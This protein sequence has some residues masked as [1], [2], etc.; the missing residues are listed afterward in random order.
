MTPE[1]VSQHPLPPPSSPP[2]W[3]WLRAALPL[4]ALFVLGGC[5]L[6][7][8]RVQWREPDSF[9]QSPA[10]F[11]PAAPQSATL[12]ESETYA[13]AAQAVGPAVVNIDTQERVRGMFDDYPSE[14]NQPRYNTSEGSGVIIDAAGYILTN[15]HVV[16]QAGEG[17]RISITMQNGKKMPGTIIGSDA[18]TDIALI[19]VEAPG[20]LPVA[21]MGTVK[22]LI[23]GQMAVAIG[24]PLGLQF[25][26][27]H[28][29][30]SALGRPVGEYE[31]LI[32]T[33]CAINP[34]NSGG[35]L[36]NLRG[37]VIGINTLV[38]R[39]GQNI[40]FAIP[41]DNALQIASV[42]KQYGKVKR[43]WLGVRVTTNEPRLVAA[44]G[45][46]DVTGVVVINVSPRASASQTL[47]QR[48]VILSI[49]GK[50]VRTQEDYRSIEKTLK[51]GQH[52][53]V[54]IQRED[55]R[56]EGELTVGE[57]PASGTISP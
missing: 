23:P 32:Q 16:G 14:G 6:P 38:D 15:S 31:N 19:K 53:K 51:I 18:L 22:G 33:D 20:T 7:N 41:I 12:P 49:D 44:Y 54:Q 30:V 45:L 27:T 40:G 52:V 50:A 1:P 36:A 42:L 47:Q 4:T 46:P 35:P 8:L 2:K 43:P 5:L 39:R 57:A 13:R 28:G 11:V 24:S 26:V 34:G 29:V 10:A 3:G 48:D 9:A 17:K 25:T 37:E 21:K 56:G 55:Q